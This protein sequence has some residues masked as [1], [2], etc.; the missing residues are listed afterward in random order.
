[1]LNCFTDETAKCVTKLF[2]ISDS[3]LLAD[4]SIKFR[5]MLLRVTEFGTLC[6]LCATGIN[7]IFP[8]DTVT[9]EGKRLTREYVDDV[10]ECGYLQ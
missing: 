3:V 6:V 10:I 2:K 9:T 5:E 1:V 8:L 4:N 7:I